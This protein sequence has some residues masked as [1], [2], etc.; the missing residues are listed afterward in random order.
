[1]S[2]ATSVPEVGIADAFLDHHLTLHPVDATFMGIRG[3]D[4]RLPRADGGV[5]AEER[6]SIAALRARLALASRDTREACIDAR[7]VAGEL[8]VAEATLDAR[9]RWHNPAW[10][11]G[12]AAFG[13][14]G[15]LLPQAAPYDP[16]AVAARLSAIPDFLA[17]GRARLRESGR[18]PAGW[19]ER[20]RREAR[21]SAG[22]LASGLALHETWCADWR[23]PARAAAEAFEAFAGSLDQLD[24]CDAAAGAAHLDLVMRAQH[25]LEAGPAALAAAAQAAFERLTLELEEDARAF[26]PGVGWQQITA[27]VAERFPAHPDE[28][29]SRYRHWH[30]VAQQQAASLVTPAL[31]YGLEY[32]P[33]ASPFQQVAAEMYFLFYR[34]PPPAAAGAGSVYWV[35]PSAGDPQAYLRSQNESVVKLVHAVHHGSI[36]HHTHNA[37]A[38]DAGSAL[39]RV[40]GTDC[41]LGIAFLSGGMAVEGWACHAEDLMAEVPGFYS[42]AELLLLK[43]YERR[44]AASVLVD[45]RLH[46]GIWSEAEAERFYCDEAGFPPQR[47]C[48]EV[49]RNTMFP[50]SRLM[51]WAG[52]EAIRALRRRWRGDT[53]S[54]HDT[55]LQFGH[56]PM[57]AIEESMAGDGLLK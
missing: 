33:L 37:R 3:H 18:A 19:C 15:L 26:G 51:Y 8:D 29:V 53:R 38:R 2:G 24:P 10:F 35:M 12:E 55:L 31:D 47:A 27:G 48:A 34:S 23:E 1:M 44:N 30:D 46:M 11:T 7:M 43:Q 32:R 16:E 57:A 56:V 9:P 13:L 22:F 40:A 28:V 21:A 20:A 50:G 41:A 14:I 5:A 25:G 39:G 36:G 52:V 49:V 45:V 17:D 6:R 42:P 4:G 54:F